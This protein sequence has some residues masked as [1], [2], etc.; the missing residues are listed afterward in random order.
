MADPL[1]PQINVNPST[2]QRFVA[3]KAYV[4]AHRE[5]MQR[6]DMQRAFDY[7]IAQMMHEECNLAGVEGNTAAAGYYRMAGAQRFAAL[8]KELAESPRIPARKPG[9]KEMPI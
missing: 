2:K 5:L 7:A 4:H 1:N 9:D 8:M 6:P 3:V